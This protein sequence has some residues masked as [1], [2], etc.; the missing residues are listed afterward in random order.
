MSFI[1]I[2]LFNKLFWAKQALKDKIFD[3][4]Y[5]HYTHSYPQFWGKV[6]IYQAKN[7][8]QK[9]KRQSLCGQGESNSR[10]ILGKDVF[11]H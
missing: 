4:L 9:T 5:K 7:K 8:G 3:V 2:S 11:Y 6:Y 10:L 1:K